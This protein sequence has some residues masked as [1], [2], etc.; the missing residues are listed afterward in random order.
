MQRHGIVL[1][2]PP[3]A[4]KDTITVELTK[5]SRPYVL[6]D[7]MKVG[8]AGEGKYRYVDVEKLR[9][10]RER[11]Q[12]VYENEQYE[13]RYVVDSFR[14]EELF[15]ADRVPIVHIGQL[16][17]IDALRSYEAAWFVV[18]IWCPRE[19]ARERLTERGSSDIEAR[20][21]VWDETQDELVNVLPDSFDMWFDTATIEPADA[22]ALIHAGI[23]E[24]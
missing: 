19:H 11:G 22:A 1:Y 9:Q 15:G 20:L 23:Q 2:G 18:C 10:V 21:A 8:T 3:A 13:N 17:G 16:A 6:F 12:V 7:R 24:H 4:G 5:L 14:L